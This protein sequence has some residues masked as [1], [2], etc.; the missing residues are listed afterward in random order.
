MTCFIHADLDAFYASVEQLDN[1]EYRGKPVIVGGLPGDRRSVVSAASYEARKYG[2]HSAMPTAQAYKLCP[3]GIFVRGRMDRYH[4]KSAEIM[5]IF[6]DFSPDVEQLS[7]DEAFLDI[8]GTEKLFGP[9]EDTAKRLKATITE[10]TGLTVSVGIASNKYIAKIAS[11]ISKPNGLFVIAPGE[12]EKFMRSLPVGKIWGAGEKTQEIFKKHGLKT[13]D[14]IYRLSQKTLASMFGNALG[15]FLYR[16]VRGEPAETFDR[17]RGSHSM[18]AERTFA[19]DLYDEFV[20]ESALLD[21]CE[22]LLFRLLSGQVE[23]ATI[24]LKIRYSDFSTE[25]FRET[26]QEAILTLNDFYKH[27]LDLFHRKYQRNMGIRLIGAGLIN[28]N[29]SN[30]LHQGDLFSEE[31]DKERRLEESI[32]KINSKHPGAALRRSRSTLAP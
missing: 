22:T 9:P 28:L 29:R 25:T 30:S 19:Y 2:V 26:F 31:K 24:S 13:C 15:T 3:E 20:I 21:I 14:D 23:S 11:G 32:L 6:K 5:A 17:E 4:E 18:S 16:A 27:V 1:P 7:I 8:T 10:K 12:E